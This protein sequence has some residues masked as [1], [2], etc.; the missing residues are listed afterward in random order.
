MPG[1]HVRRVIHRTEALEHV[2]RLVLAKQPDRWLATLANELR[3]DS[4]YVF[5]DPVATHERERA[6]LAIEVQYAEL[7]FGAPV[8]SHS[9]SSISM[10]RPNTNNGT[11]TVK[12]G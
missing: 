3:G 10:Q 8:E 7:A 12:I 11:A 4:G 5:R 9:A 6:A 2:H 1:H